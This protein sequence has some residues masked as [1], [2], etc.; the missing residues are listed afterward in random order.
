MKLPF[1]KQARL[2]SNFSDTYFFLRLS[3]GLIALLLPLIVWL[4]GQAIFHVPPQTSISAYYHTNMRDVLVG[5]L[6]AVGLAL[7]VYKGFSRLE[8]WLLNIAGILLACVAYFPMNPKKLLICFP[9]CN[10]DLC[11][12]Y[13]SALD[14]TPDFF[15]ENLSHKFLIPF[16]GH[17]FKI[18][19]SVHGFCAVSFFIAIAYVCAFCSRRTLHLIPDVTVRSG[20]RLTYLILGVAMVILPLATFVMI[21]TSADAGHA[22][23]NRA[24]FW[25]EA[26]GV[27]V[28][29]TFWL[30]KTREN[31]LYGADEQYLN[32]RG[33]PE[34]L[35][36]DDP[37]ATASG[38]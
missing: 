28:F 27:W 22:C 5:S 18:D 29:A 31:Y 17:T 8:D 4:G 1:S 30:V 19:L 26:V 32:R 15:L 2:E 14:R 36:R 13:S 12:P 21:Q 25:V 37:S 11:V 23:T 20:Y 16:G 33:I 34:A 24:V 38:T 35:A 10:K 3:M 9:P 6:F 7:L